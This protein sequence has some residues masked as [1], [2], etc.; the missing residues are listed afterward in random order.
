MG[1]R[2]YPR[3]RGARPAITSRYRMVWLVFTRD[4]WPLLL[5]VP[6]K[7]CDCDWASVQGDVGRFPCS[8]FTPPPHPLKPGLVPARR[9]YS[10]HNP[11][12]ISPP[13]QPLPWEGAFKGGYSPLAAKVTGLVPPGLLL[14][15]P[16]KGYCLRHRPAVCASSG[17]G[18]GRPCAASPLPPSNGQ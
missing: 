8:G 9:C 10:S 3:P 7:D 2:K 11:C 17:P 5:P 14:M 18:S 15:G 1:G 16:S 12:G 13:S 4:T 6:G